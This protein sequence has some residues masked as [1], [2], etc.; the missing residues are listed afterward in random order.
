M[1]LTEEKLNTEKKS[2]IH[3]RTKK[4]KQGSQ[5]IE[6]TREFTLEGKR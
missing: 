6:V 1:K 5:S 3:P 2:E 4:Q